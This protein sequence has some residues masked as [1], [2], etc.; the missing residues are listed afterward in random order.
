MNL[1]AGRTMEGKHRE[2]DAIASTSQ[3]RV[4][5]LLTL[6]SVCYCTAAW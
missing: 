2:K 4:G 1:F 6:V 5:H 3:L